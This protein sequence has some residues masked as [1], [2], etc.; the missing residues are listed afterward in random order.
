MRF[1]GNLVWCALG[2][3][4]A[5]VLWVCFGL[6]LCV[7][8]V[9]FRLGL[10]CFKFAKLSFAPFGKK[11]KLHYMRHPIANTIWAVLFGW[12]LFLVHLAGG[13]ICCATIVGIP[14]G[15]QIFKFSVLSFA[16]Y[17]AKV[18]KTKK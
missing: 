13:L 3:L 15:R 5:S 18:S 4:V 12:E 10:Q 14:V 8:I 16:P 9:G 2:G 17:G 7:T 1:I 6:M 11:V